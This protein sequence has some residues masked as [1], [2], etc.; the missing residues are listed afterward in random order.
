MLRY[1]YEAFICSFDDIVGADGAC[2]AEH[3]TAQWALPRGNRA[4][5]GPWRRLLLARAQ[6]ALKAVRLQAIGVKPT[7]FFR[8]SFFLFRGGGLR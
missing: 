6:A 3:P 5:T 7:S 2:D 8:A 4:A 1:I